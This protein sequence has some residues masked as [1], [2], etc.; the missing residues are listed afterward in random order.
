MSEKFPAGVI[1]GDTVQA[2]FNDAQENEYALPAVNV[3]GTNSIN[4][5]LETAAEVN[6]PVMIQFSNGGGVF[7]A[8]KSLSND[9]QRSVDWRRTFQIPR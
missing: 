5:V 2:I 6:S 4:A 7:Y 1:T 9:N 3:V 8:G